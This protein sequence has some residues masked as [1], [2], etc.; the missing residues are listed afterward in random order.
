MS[1]LQSK[2]NDYLNRSVENFHNSDAPEDMKVALAHVV[3]VMRLSFNNRLTRCAGRAKSR[4]TPTFHGNGQITYT[5]TGQVLELAPK[6]LARM[7][8]EQVFDT[9]SHELAH[10]LDY[11]VR[12]D[13]LRKSRRADTHGAS[14]KRIHRWMGGTAERCYKATDLEGG[15]AGL[16]RKVKRHVITYKGKEYTVTSHRK[17]KYERMGLFHN[18]EMELVRS[19][20]IG[21]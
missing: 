21:G 11:Y 9:V 14:W 17:T 8:D 16:R 18:G 2:V 10:L 7:S 4:F 15:T 5:A 6:V 12:A 1:N 19:F 3:S 20:T 13:E